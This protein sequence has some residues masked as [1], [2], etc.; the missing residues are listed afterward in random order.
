MHLCR[1]VCVVSTEWF[2][3]SPHCHLGMTIWEAVF[4]ELRG[5]FVPLKGSERVGEI[6]LGDDELG[7][8]EATR[9]LGWKTN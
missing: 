5:G 8:E 9:K 1:L 4:M 3:P 7:F 2:D 6:S